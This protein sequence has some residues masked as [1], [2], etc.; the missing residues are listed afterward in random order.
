MNKTNQEEEIYKRKITRAKRIKKIK[1]KKE[2]DAFFK[3]N[4]YFFCILFFLFIFAL[5]IVINKDKLLIDQQQ[6]NLKFANVLIDQLGSSNMMKTNLRLVE[7]IDSMETVIEI[8][9]LMN[10]KSQKELMNLKEMVKMDSVK[11]KRSNEY[12]N[13]NI[14]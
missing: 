12:I 13:E 14:R 10:Q 3:K 8:F 1:R 4:V 2:I 7:K 6:K 5:T 9:Y 11:F